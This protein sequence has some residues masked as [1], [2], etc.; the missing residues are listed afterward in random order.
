MN[1]RLTH[2]T[3]LL[4]IVFLCACSSSSENK[5]L[6]LAAAA[7]MQYALQ[8][9]VQAFQ[10]DSPVKCHIV[11]A[12]S[13]KLTAQIKNG[14]P[15]DIFLSANKKYTDELFR[16]GFTHNKP[17][18]YAYGNL[19]LW[20]VSDTVIPQ[21]NRLTDSVVK[22]IAIANPE[23]APYGEAAK[24]VL[25]HLPG[26]SQIIPKIIY[27]ESIAQV[28]QFVLSSP[29]VWGFTAKST[30]VSAPM[31]NKGNWTDIDTKLYS[32]IIQTA[33]IVK[34]KGQDIHPAAAA[35]FSFLK[36]EKAQEILQQ[37]GYSTNEPI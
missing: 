9:L 11:I 29:D 16:A 21:L 6:T 17:E 26:I 37:N 15:Y 18:I 34:Q 30:V 32:P 22:H 10:E 4:A 35:F 33:V 36:S 5:P 23:T 1:I 2:I 3:A 19:V 7:N 28:N 24:E 14:A 27:A 12:S 20:S 25:H 13:G 31:K 8:E